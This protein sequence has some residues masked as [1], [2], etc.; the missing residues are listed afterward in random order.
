[1]EDDF[2]EKQV[3]FFVF[4]VG[5]NETYK[6]N[7]VTKNLDYNLKLFIDNFHF[8]EIFLYNYF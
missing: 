6:N 7:Q 4:I 1:M 8:E 5:K 2:N 3:Y